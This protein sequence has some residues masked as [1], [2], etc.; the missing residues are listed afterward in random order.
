MHVLVTGATG[1]VGGLVCLM[2][3]KP[4]ISHSYKD[5]AGALD[6]AGISA[7][8]LSF[9]LVAGFYLV[10]ALPACGG[11]DS[12]SGE[13]TAGPFTTS[14]RQRGAV[15]S[16]SRRSERRGAP[17]VGSSSRDGAV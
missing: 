7:Y 16:G 10:F 13:S 8:Q 6:P 4:L 15:P 5:A 14:P 1:Y 12:A 9:L 2:A 11:S 3:C 17:D